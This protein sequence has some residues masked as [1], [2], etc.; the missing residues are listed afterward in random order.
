[1]SLLKKHLGF[2]VVA[3][4]YIGIWAL[5]SRLPFFW[6]GTML[7]SK[8]ATWFYTQSSFSLFPPN[9]INPG[10]P[11]VFWIVLNGLVEIIRTQFIGFPLGNAAFCAFDIVADVSTKDLLF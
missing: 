4:I 2:I 9:E 11:T 10:H 7:G 8:L 5:Y 1:M 6:D 3:C